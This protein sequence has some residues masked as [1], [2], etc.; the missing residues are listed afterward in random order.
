MT[1][2][3]YQ[4]KAEI[5][6]EEFSRCPSCS[7]I[8]KKLCDKLN[9]Q[10]TTYVKPPKEVL[11]P[12]KSIKQGIEVTTWYTKEECKIWKLPIPEGY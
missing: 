2:K 11:I 10:K 1:V 6:E 3:C 8:H 9:A 5:V 4:C 7:E 12:F